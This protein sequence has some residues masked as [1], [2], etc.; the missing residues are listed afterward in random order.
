MA[1]SKMTYFL[2]NY[3][4]IMVSFV[5]SVASLSLFRQKMELRV[6]KLEKF[7]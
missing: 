5:L 2:K 6:E 4:S 3:L 1:L 7:D